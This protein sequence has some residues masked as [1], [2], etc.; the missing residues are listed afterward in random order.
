[1]LGYHVSIDDVKNLKY[2]EGLESAQIFLTNRSLHAPPNAFEPLK[3][4]LLKKELTAEEKKSS[5]YVNLTAT[6]NFIKH[7]KIK[8]LVIHA[9]Y[10]TQLFSTKD[11]VFAKSLQ[12]A[13]FYTTCCKFIERETKIKAYYNI[14]L[15]K[16]TSEIRTDE[17]SKLFS[18]AKKYILLETETDSAIPEFVEGRELHLC[19]DTAHVSASGKDIMSA[20]KELRKLIQ[21]IHLNGNLLEVGSK[22]DKHCAFIDKENKIP[23]LEEFIKYISHF[24]LP[25]ILERGAEVPLKEIKKIQQI[26]DS[27]Y[28]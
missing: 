24:D 17:L 22:R 15:P 18:K 13:Y 8:I 27:T 14:H 3:K 21:C 28:H 19:F 6:I 20:F 23:N 26:F 7:F 16:K 9:S 25:I 1:M 4:L 11:D 2:I 12:D 5:F 10:T